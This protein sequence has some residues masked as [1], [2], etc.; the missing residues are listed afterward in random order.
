MEVEGGVGLRGV[1]A[2]AQRVEVDLALRRVDEVEELVLHEDLVARDVVLDEAVGHHVEVEPFDALE[3]ELRVDLLGE[4][5]GGQAP[6][7]ALGDGLDDREGVVGGDVLVAVVGAAAEVLRALEGDAAALGRHADAL[8]PEEYRVLI[9]EDLDLVDGDVDVLQR[10]VKRVAAG[11]A[12][13]A[14]E[15]EDARRHVEAHVDGR[16]GD[17]VAAVVVGR[18]HLVA[19]DAVALADRE[20]L[21]E[22]AELHLAALV[23]QRHLGR[24]R[25]AAVPEHPG[26]LHPEA[27]AVAH[28]PADVLEGE[29]VAVARELRVAAPAPAAP[30]GH[31]VGEL[32]QH[33]LLAEVGRVG[34]LG[35]VDLV[36]AL[37]DV[38]LVAPEVHVGVGQAQPVPVHL[39]PAAAEGLRAGV[40]LAGGRGDGDGVG[41]PQRHEVDGP[42]V[43]HRLVAD[44]PHGDLRL[45]RRADPPPQRPTPGVERAVVEVAPRE[46]E[47]VLKGGIAAALGLS[48]QRQ[49]GAVPLREG[50]R[51]PAGVRDVLERAEVQLEEG[52]GLQGTRAHGVG[53]VH[54]EGALL[55]GVGGEALLEGGGEVLRLAALALRDVRRQLLEEGLRTRPVEVLRTRR[56][57]AREPEREGAKP[58]AS[59]HEGRS[60]S[61]RP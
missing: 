4:G 24:A 28:A 35:R 54:D 60:V 14:R 21:G 52:R 12:V 13:V 30:G 56:G 40:V 33:P 16:V 43:D 8:L 3:G 34:H 22:A 49:Q 58:G 31:L 45:L 25:G 5:E 41:P 37:V 19:H 1:G 61:V 39:A 7:L 11:G 38:D 20:R 15:R 59:G 2:D 51:L 23:A 44:D 26:A 36:E 32:P 57:R 29:V 6:A 50:G 42:E 48:E 17:R 46:T 55:G 10:G 53:D 9:D 27:P 18:A 47:E